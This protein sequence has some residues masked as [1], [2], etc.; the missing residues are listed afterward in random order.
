MSSTAGLERSIDDK[1]ES[2]YW[3]P[4]NAENRLSISVIFTSIKGTL[5]ALAKARER[6]GFVGAS[7][8]IVAVQTVPYPLPLDSPPV[9]FEFIVKRFENMTNPLLP[10][11][12][13][14][15]YLCRDSVEALKQILDSRSLIVIGIR[16]RWWPTRDKRLAR[17]L[18]HA[19]YEVISVETE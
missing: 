12:P 4:V 19:G 2:I 7:I 13:I 15:A 18:R 5:K 8:V 17:K 1:S 14:V 9:P 16:K 11:A 10:K 3:Q 6:A